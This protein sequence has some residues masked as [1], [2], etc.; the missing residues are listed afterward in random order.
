MWLN[1]FYENDVIKI[2]RG[3]YMTDWNLDGVNDY[4]TLVDRAK[5]MCRARVREGSYGNA[6]IKYI[7]C[8]TWL[9]DKCNEINLWT[10]WQGHGLTDFS[11]VKIMLVG[12]DWGS[13]KFEADSIKR[14]QEIQNGER[15]IDYDENMN[16]PTNIKLCKLFLHIGH[17]YDLSKSHSDLFFTNYSLGYRRDSETGNMT[18]ALLRQDKEAFETLVKIVQPRV[19]IC[20]GKL[21]SEMVLGQT[22]KGFIKRLK[23]GMILSYDYPA[24]SKIKVYCVGHC[25]KRGVSNR[26]GIKSMEEDWMRIAEDMRKNNLI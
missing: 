7:D 3:D 19:I 9:T 16:S 12:Q 20:L 26:G 24:N 5:E 14:I 17:D 4:G 21:V 23:A 22:I 1:F 15:D 6:K 18:K 11:D 8:D 25:G 10:Y 2:T 13:E